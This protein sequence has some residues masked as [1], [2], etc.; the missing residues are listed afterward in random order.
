LIS[1]FIPRAFKRKK[2]RKR[3]KG[4]REREGGKGTKARTA[5]CALV[6]IYFRSLLLFVTER[7]KRRKEIEGEERMKATTSRQPEPDGNIRPVP[8]KNLSDVF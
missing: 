1:I 4:G 2:E 8:T 7:G 3:E 5:N 6:R